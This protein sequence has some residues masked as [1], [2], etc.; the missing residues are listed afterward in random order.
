MSKSL[1]PV[2]VRVGC[3]VAWDAYATRE[4][5]VEASE[6]AKEQAAIDAK[7]GYDFGLA[8]P[9][10]ISGPDAEGLWWVTVS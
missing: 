7:R 10:E 4:E 8:T 5:A 3:K 1:S 2:K 9:G 6:A